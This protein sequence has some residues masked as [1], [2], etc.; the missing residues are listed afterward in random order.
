M[1]GHD[2]TL[3]LLG[4]LFADCK[5]LMKHLLF[6]KHEYKYARLAKINDGCISTEKVIILKKIKTI[7]FIGIFYNFIENKNI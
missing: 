6:I 3:F 7:H 4:R 1:N 5:L 2:N